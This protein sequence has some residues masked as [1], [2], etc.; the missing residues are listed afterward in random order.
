[1]LRLYSLILLGLNLLKQMA[2]TMEF[3]GLQFW[4]II[5]TEQAM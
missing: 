5:S 2:E 3:K 1:M 4:A